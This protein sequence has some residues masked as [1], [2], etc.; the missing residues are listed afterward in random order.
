MTETQFLNR[1]AVRR[2]SLI[3]EAELLQVASGA[4]MV[5]RISEIGARGCYVDTLNPFAVSEAIKVKIR[6]Q[7]A[8]L[9]LPAKVIY[10]HA[11]FGMGVLFGEIPDT[12]QAVLDAWLGDPAP[13]P[14]P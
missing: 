1:R 12:Q 5:A 11:G 8:V 9:E 6:H 3:A 7:D 14:I 10:T 2:L 4:K 13:D